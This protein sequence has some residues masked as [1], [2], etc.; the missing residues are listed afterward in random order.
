MNLVASMTA[1]LLESERQMF[2]LASGSCTVLHVKLQH[3]DFELQAIAIPTV[4]LEGYTG[5]HRLSLNSSAQ[6]S[7]QAYVGDLLA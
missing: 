6:L 5:T 2:L 7:S 3:P 4:H 1:M